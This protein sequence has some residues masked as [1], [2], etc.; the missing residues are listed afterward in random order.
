VEEKSFTIRLPIDLVDQLDMRTQINYRSRTKEIQSLLIFALDNLA[1][2]A[3]E[4]RA[5]AKLSPDQKQTP[6][7]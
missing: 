3:K 4:S 5:E 7:E 1:Q 6:E 2:E